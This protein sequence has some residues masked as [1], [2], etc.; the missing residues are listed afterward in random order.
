MSL[1]PPLGV[2]LV[3]LCA[4][5][6]ARVMPYERGKLAERCMRVERDETA[7]SM[8]QHV[9][10]YREGATGAMGTTG[11]GCGCN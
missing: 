10:E 4:A 9:H 2:A 1:P 7:V 5:S 3:A 6:C 11:G 8:E